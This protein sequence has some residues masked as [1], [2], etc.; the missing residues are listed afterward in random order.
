ML[1]R[2]TSEDMTTALKTIL[3]KD[4]KDVADDKEIKDAF[5]NISGDEL[6]EK[7]LKTFE[8]IFK[9]SK[10]KFVKSAKV[11]NSMFTGLSTIVLVP[12]FMIWL[13]RTCNKMT[14][15]ARAKDLALQN[16]NSSDPD[17]VKYYP[18]EEIYFAHP[19]TA[20]SMQGFLKNKT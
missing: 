9:D 7:A 20:I 3:G 18:R 14:R 4:L 19:N 17:K 13:A 10:N 6:K 12:T 5:K 16:N 1:A 15:K 11:Y 2:D 8:N